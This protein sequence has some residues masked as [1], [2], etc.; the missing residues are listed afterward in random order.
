MKKVR[1][2][3]IERHSAIIEIEEDEDALDVALEIDS[4]LTL[5]TIETVSEEVL[6]EWDTE[7]PEDRQA[8]EA[9]SQERDK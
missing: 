5:D 7:T 3:W 9:Y 4:D 2:D 1:I 6:K 8:D